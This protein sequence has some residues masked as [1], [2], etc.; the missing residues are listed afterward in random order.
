MSRYIFITIRISHL[1]V[2]SVISC[3][4]FVVLPLA[5]LSCR[6]RFA[7]FHAV[8]VVCEGNTAVTTSI[9]AE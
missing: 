5:H 6:K 2:S 7:F 4:I 3:K 1:D 8:I 9:A